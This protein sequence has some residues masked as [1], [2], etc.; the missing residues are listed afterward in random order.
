[1]SENSLTLEDRLARLHAINVRPGTFESDLDHELTAV[2]KSVCRYYTSPNNLITALQQPFFNYTAH[3]TP[4]ALNWDFYNMVIFMY[5]LGIEFPENLMAIKNYL[6]SKDSTLMRNIR[7]HLIRHRQLSFCEVIGIK[8]NMLYFKQVDG[9]VRSLKFIYKATKGD[10]KSTEKFEEDV[11]SRT[12]L[13]AVLDFMCLV[14]FDFIDQLYMMFTMRLLFLNEPVLAAG[15]RHL[16][17]MREYLDYELGEH[18]L[19]K[20]ENIEKAELERA[21]ENPLRNSKKYMYART[22][23]FYVLIFFVCNLHVSPK[24]F[25]IKTHH[26]SLAQTFVVSPVNKVADYLNSF[27]VKGIFKEGAVKEQPK[28]KPAPKAEPEK[29]QPKATPAPKAEPEEQQPKAKPAPPP[30]PEDEEEEFTIMDLIYNTDG[31]NM[32]FAAYKDSAVGYTATTHQY[33]TFNELSATAKKTKAKKVVCNHDTKMCKWV[34]EDVNDDEISTTY[35][36]AGD[37]EVGN[38]MS[39]T[40]SSMYMDRTI[41]LHGVVA[42]VSKLFTGSIRI[43]VKDDCKIYRSKA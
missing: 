28:A 26:C 30:E 39:A 32:P 33:G 13:T 37:T 1:M 5:L 23:V 43:C 41:G 15:Y 40:R 20:A 38:F 16:F 22:A 25:E 9:V 27:S 14:C 3:G 6:D 10:E 4:R 29:Q 24:S 17:A 2:L 21:K 34:S 7:G 42:T 19:I 35:A 18:Y 36:T 8:N 12:L 11:R 31:E